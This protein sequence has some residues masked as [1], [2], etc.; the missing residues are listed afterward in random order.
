MITC[1]LDIKWDRKQIKW[2]SSFNEQNV[3]AGKQLRSQDR[4]GDSDY[5]LYSLV[6]AVTVCNEF[7]QF[8]S[9][10]FHHV[11]VELH[12]M[13]YSKRTCGGWKEFSLFPRYISYL[14]AI[15]K[16]WL[17]RQNCSQH[18]HYWHWR[19][20]TFFWEQNTVCKVGISPMIRP[21]IVLRYPVPLPRLRK[22]SPCCSFSAS[23]TSE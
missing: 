11:L 19:S 15:L 6:K 2:R 22:E 23:M 21:T 13:I 17:W 18:N 16:T 9:C 3:I 14:N 1:F 12:A 5:F 7:L 10:I 20:L 4:K 8:L